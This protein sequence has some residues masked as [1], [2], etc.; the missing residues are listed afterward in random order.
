MGPS[1]MPEPTIY[2]A[3]KVITLA[4]DEPEGFAVADGRI[5]ASGTLAELRERYPAAEVVDL[6]GATV[7]PGFHDAHL[8]LA[9]TADQL[10][11][12]DLSHT[13]VQSLA[14]LT[15]RVRQAALRTAP[16]RWILGSRYDDGKMAEGRTLT[17]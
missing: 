1:A 7:V 16:D 5:A 12:L 2:T 4:G 3:N 11:Q 14:A 8:H 15:E 13:Q 17:R 10:L 9:S 6:G